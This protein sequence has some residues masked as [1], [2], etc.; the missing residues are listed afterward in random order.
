MDELKAHLQLLIA[1]RQRLAAT[2]GRE[3]RPLTSKE[4]RKLAKLTAAI[5]GLRYTISELSP[6]PP[7]PPTTAPQASPATIAAVHLGGIYVLTQ[8]YFIETTARES[9]VLILTFGIL[10]VLFAGLSA[11][12]NWYAASLLY[13]KWAN[14][15]MLV[16]PNA[17]PKDDPVLSARMNWTFRASIIVGLLSALCGPVAAIVAVGIPG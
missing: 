16:N 4:I 12:W 1:E 10:L 13:Q 15:D 7:A 5:D 9:G 8:A 2:V 6:V 17:W 3:H 11:W 14:P